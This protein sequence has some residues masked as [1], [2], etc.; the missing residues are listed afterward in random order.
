MFIH[1]LASPVIR[2]AKA[3]S[4]YAYLCSHTAVELA[5]GVLSLRA[6]QAA[7]HFSTKV[8]V[9]VREY[10]RMYCGGLCEEA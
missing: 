1:M 7:L 9:Y 4:A 10:D 5:V 2:K 3:V 6:P 8:F